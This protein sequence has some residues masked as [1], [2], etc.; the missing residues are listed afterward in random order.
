MKQFEFTSK[1]S[2]MMD[3]YVESRI[4]EGYQARAERYYLQE[5]DALSKTMHDEPFVTKELIEAW[6]AI[7][8]YLA[9]RTKIARHN[10]IRA[11]AV[12]A[13]VRDG[14]SYVPDTSRLKENST[15]VPYV[16]TVEEISRIVYAADNLSYRGNAPTRHL[17]IPA[18]IRMLY[19]CGLR[20]NEALRLKTEDVN[21]S[22]GVLSIY[23]AKG[24]KDRYVPM[25]SSLTEYLKKYNS[26]L[27]KAREWF[28]PSATSHYQRG[29]FYQNFR[30]LLFLSGIPHTGKGPRVHDLRHTFAVH[31]LETQLSSGCN[32]MVI[33]PRLAVYLGHKHYR[34]TCW[35]IHLTAASYPELSKKLDMA[36]AGIIP[37]FGGGNDE[38]D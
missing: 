5:F 23:N 14:K 21:L 29:S 17:V 2:T 4:S 38:E 32:P 26:A 16:F 33:L 20:V 37:I 1:L 11:F 7:K 15:F 3:L 6:D 13:Y 25:H 9:N 36:F 34:D 8:P 24:G 35:Y 28:F 31:T 12:F 19:G 30:E 27:P 10:T 18:V 22:T